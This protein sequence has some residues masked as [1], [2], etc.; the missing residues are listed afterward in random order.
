[1]T[2]AAAAA[3]AAAPSRALRHLDRLIARRPQKKKPHVCQ[4]ALQQCRRRQVH[5]RFGGCSGAAQLRVRGLRSE[6]S[7]AEEL[8]ILSTPTPHGV[9]NVQVALE[10]LLAGA[11]HAFDS[12]VEAK[13]QVIV[14]IDH[15][16]VAS[17]GDLEPRSLEVKRQQRRR[18]QR[19]INERQRAEVTVGVVQW[20]RVLAALLRLV[21]NWHIDAANAILD[22]VRPSCWRSQVSR[23]AMTNTHIN[24]VNRTSRLLV[25]LAKHNDGS[26]QNVRKCEYMTVCIE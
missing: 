23:S 13:R 24:N 14:A 5:C 21:Q 12:R 16:H 25:F 1:M 15:A 20:K 7:A 6:A 9:L 3:A 11:L 4:R 2:A 10:L 18:R 19:V 22:V 26:S 17:G 8:R